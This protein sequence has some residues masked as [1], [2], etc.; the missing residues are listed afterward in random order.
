MSFRSRAV[1]CVSLGLAANGVPDQARPEP[2]ALTIRSAAEEALE[3]NP[4]LRSARHA[5]EAARGR[6]LQAGLAPNPELSL[7]A[8]SDFAFA[9]EG[10]RDQDVSIS[11]RFPIAGRLARA[12]AVER[13]EVDLASAEVRDFERMLIADV[14]G[15]VVRLLALERTLAAREGVIDAVRR[16]VETS[17]LR[18][19]AAQVSEADVGLLAID[20][21]SLEQEQ[22][23]DALDRATE[24]ARLN[25]LLH[26]PPATPVVVAGDVAAPI[27]AA[28][29]PA[30]LAA[31]A[32]DRRPD[33]LR[34]RLEAERA[35][36]SASLARAEIWEDWG[37]EARYDRTRGT[38]DVAG[39]EVVDRDQLLG[40]SL[41]VP[42]P[43]WNRN[44]G[45]I[46]EAISLERQAGSRREALERRVHEEIEATS[47]RVEA[48][49]QVARLYGDTVLPRAE[50]T[51]TLLARGYREGLTP[52]SDLVQAEQQLADASLAYARTLGE[53]RQAEVELEAAAALNPLLDDST[54][55]EA[56]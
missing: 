50:R 8:S 56:P 20:L 2:Q 35:R 41:Q 36:A 44:Q 30:E 22:R 43:L 39:S 21:A 23:L 37:V 47:H 48:L 40:L 29:S 34:L 7:G 26:R 38:L 51:V 13:V 3:A 42:L 17:E 53:L 9:S 4:E 32:L 31:T 49:G 27:L 16:L 25:R 5:V 52:I 55:E 45:R 46:A 18:L 10:E 33:L 14:Q 12:R 24:A 28:R 1:L 15:S 54:S 11:Q 6:L 19:R